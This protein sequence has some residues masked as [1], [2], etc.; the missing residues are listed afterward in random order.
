MKEL[1]DYWKKFL[2]E[3][4]ENFFVQDNINLIARRLYI[5]LEVEESLVNVP[6]L[7]ENKIIK[8]LG[9]G[10]YGLACLLNNDHV[11][12][13]G[14]KRTKKD[15][16]IYSHYYEYPSSDFII[17]ELGELPDGYFYVEMNKAYTL[18]EYL[19]M[20]G[21][22]PTSMG[23]LSNL[24]YDMVDLVKDYP[25]SDFNFQTI[26]KT[27]KQ[28]VLPYKTS[29]GNVFTRTELISL[30][31]AVAQFIKYHGTEHNYDFHAGNIG[32]VPT[33]PSGNNMKFMIFD[34]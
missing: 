8:I 22:E 21:R 31:V 26:N 19:E 25:N 2:N 10:A 14:L 27:I 13:I 5:S 15:F 3:K 34:F 17:Y 24:M 20:T 29:L 32:V 18:F 12:K 6:C 30:C 28:F 7:S 1:K 4:K 9:A 16:Q 11:F 23:G 33:S